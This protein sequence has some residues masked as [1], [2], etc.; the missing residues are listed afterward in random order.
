MEHTIEATALIALL[1]LLFCG[2]YLSNKKSE[3]ISYRGFYMSPAVTTALKGLMAIVIICHHYCL[4]NWSFVEHTRFMSIIPLNGG[5][6]SLA[7]F[8]FLS[9]YGVT[10]DRKSVV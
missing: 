5:N 8:L 1:A 4:Y 6:F 7:I 10:K 3:E 9:G 2:N